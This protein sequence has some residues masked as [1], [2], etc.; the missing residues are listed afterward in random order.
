MNIVF[1]NVF[2]FCLEIKEVEVTGE[3]SP[4]PIDMKKQKK[5]VR[6]KS[7]DHAE[8]NVPCRDLG[9]ADHEGWLLKKC[10]IGLL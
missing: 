2:L 6:K 5:L 3:K 10:K 7:L 1:C 9:R 8:L 4:E